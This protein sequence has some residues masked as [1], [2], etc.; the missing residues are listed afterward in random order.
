MRDTIG[1]LEKSAF[2]RYQVCANRS[3]VG[4]VMA[5]RSRGVRAIFLRFSGEDS[6]QIGDVPGE[7]RVVRR[8]QSCTL[9]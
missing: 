2:Q 6:G 9:S 7:P 5:P 8:S 1:K 4:K 3:T